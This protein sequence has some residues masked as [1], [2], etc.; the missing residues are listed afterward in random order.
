MI[1]LSAVILCLLISIAGCG[2]HFPA[3]SAN[4]LVTGRSVWV[5]FISNETVSPSAQTVLR[6]VLL[7]ECHQL[8]GLKPAG[9]LGDADYIVNG[10]I[11]SYS[12]TPVSYTANDQIR[13][14]RLSIGVELD[15]RRKGDTVP[16]WK[17]LITGTQ[18]YPVS[19]DLALQSN[20]ADAALAAASVSIADKFISATEQD[21]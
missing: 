3:A 6:R 16:I 8:R 7:Q 14:Y 10:A 17:G 18:D 19:A 21:Y 15:L 1:F 11:R 2:Y 12:V 13:E 4:R 5:G 20:A 9:D